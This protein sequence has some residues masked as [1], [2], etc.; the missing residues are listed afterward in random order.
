MIAIVEEYALHLLQSSAYTTALEHGWWENPPDVTEAL[1]LLHCEVAEAFMAW[2]AGEIEPR[3]VDGKPEGFAS[4]LAD[5]IIYALSIGGATGV[6]VARA[7][8]EKMAWNAE[9]VD[10]PRGLHGK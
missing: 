1:A 2:N 5:V 6:D 8:I 9:R 10:R 4:E 7:V 3:S